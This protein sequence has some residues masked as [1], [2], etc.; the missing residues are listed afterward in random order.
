[1]V[2]RA[3]S[4]AT[5]VVVFVATPVVS[6]T[7]SDS[8]VSGASVV[9]GVISDTAPTKVVLPTPKPPAIT[10]LTEMGSFTSATP[11][12]AQQALEDLGPRSPVDVGGRPV[13]RQQIVGVD[14]GHQDPGHPERD[15]QR[16][17]HLGHGDGPLAE[18]D[19]AGLLEAQPGQPCPADVRGG[20]QRLE[21]EVVRPRTRPAPGEGIDGDDPGTVLVARGHGVGRADSSARSAGVSTWPIRATSRLIS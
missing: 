18:L 16:G 21:P 9:S 1:M 14:V 5:V 15:P 20:D 3:K 17:G 11:Q 8:W 7:P 13:D 6:S 4:M 12:A 2:R 19:D 10:I